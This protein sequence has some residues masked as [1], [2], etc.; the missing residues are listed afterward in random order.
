MRAGR[1]AGVVALA[2]ILAASAA[3]HSGDAQT[4]PVRVC[5]AAAT[6]GP[7]PDSQR[8]CLRVL[9][10]HEDGSALITLGTA[11]DQ[12]RWY[13]LPALDGGPVRQGPVR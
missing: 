5:F 9:R 11:R 3:A 12:V 4:T 6:W 1:I 2:L 13:Q 10:L 8:P 7:A